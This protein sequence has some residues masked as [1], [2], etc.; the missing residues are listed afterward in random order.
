MY[1][2]NWT[3]EELAR[4]D[5]AFNLYGD[6]FDHIAKFVGTRSPAQCKSRLKLNGTYNAKN[7]WLLEEKLKV[8]EAIKMFG[9]DWSKVAAYV[10][11][12]TVKQI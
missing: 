12:R 4:L 8:L 2:F 5:E 10:A 6:K 7:V 1:R 3:A 11:P 9:D